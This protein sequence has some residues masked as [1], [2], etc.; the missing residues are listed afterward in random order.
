VQTVYDVFALAPL[1]AGVVDP[2][3]GSALV[4]GYFTGQEL[5]HLL[6]F[7]LVDSPA[8]PGEY[9]P[10]ASGLR[11]RYDPSRPKFDVVTAIEIGDLD[12]GYRA[13]DIGGNDSHLYSL[14]CPLYLGLILVAIPKYTKGRLTLQAKNK[15]GQPLKSR[16]E[17]LDDP[18]DDTPYLLPPAGTLD[19]AGLD[20]ETRKGAVREIKEWQAIMDHLRSLPATG[21]G[22]LP[23]IPVDERAAEVRAI[24]AG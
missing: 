10:R 21:P 19:A 23:V 24:K 11:F 13:I 15:D 6:E 5:K 4:T 2:T 9:F 18:R 3:A 14:T 8:H 12:R 1:G 16:V 20:T 22:E 7:L 17:A